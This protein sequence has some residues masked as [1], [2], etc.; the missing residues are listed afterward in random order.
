VPP[1]EERIETIARAGDRV[2]TVAVHVPGLNVFLAVGGGVRD[3]NDMLA[4][5]A[6]G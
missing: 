3:H 6:T 1:G 5:Q 2:T 4:T